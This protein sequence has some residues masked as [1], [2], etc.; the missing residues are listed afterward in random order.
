[1]SP[2]P[3]LVTGRSF[4]S[5]SPTASSPGT[6]SEVLAAAGINAPTTQSFF[7]YVLL[8]VTCG[9]VHLRQASAAA[10]ADTAVHG[11]LSLLNQGRSSRSSGLQ[12]LNNPW[13]VYLGLAVLDVEGNYLV[14]R[15]YQYTSITSVTLL[16]STTIPAV[17]VL[18][19]LIFRHVFALENTVCD[20][21]K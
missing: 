1:M 21:R 13:W 4:I 2:Y 14:T 18:S 5:P 8:A 12:L 17:M 7:N 19:W 3:L 16:D 11:D 6:T 9:A 20:G 15:A 10:R